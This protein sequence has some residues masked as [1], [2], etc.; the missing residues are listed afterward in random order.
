MRRDLELLDRVA[1]G[2]SAGA[3]RLYGFCPPCLSLGR[4]QSRDDV[5]WQACIRDG[6]DVVKRPT[7][8]RAV[9][10]DEEV[11]YSVTCRT[12]D[13]VFGGTVLESCRRIHGVLA[14]GL[15]MMGIETLLHVPAG[16]GR[17]TATESA[18]TADCFARLSAHELM[19]I[20]GR[21]LVGS[22]QARRARALLQ[23]GSVPLHRPATAEYLRGGA[24]PGR[25]SSIRDLVRAPVHRDDVV[26]ALAQ[27]FS[28]HLG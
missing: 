11:T 21:K 1:E 16:D 13:A 24:G 27:A 14:A 6:V 23:H 19:D 3:V 4:L 5:D 18:A 12:D 10:H 28:G 20:R 7:G 17:L 8:G 9:L 15:M 2:R 25:A 22:A 26:V